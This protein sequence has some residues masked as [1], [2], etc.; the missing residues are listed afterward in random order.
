M[1]S[2][3]PKGKPASQRWFGLLLRLLPEDFRDHFG[4]EMETVIRHQQH[5]AQSAGRGAQARFWWETGASLVTAALREHWEILVQDVGFALRLLRH[6]P[7]FALVAVLIIGLAIG[8]NTAAFTAANAI[9]IQPLPFA[10]GTHLVHLMQRQPGAGVDAL[11]FSVA[12]I[13]D[14]R[15]QSQTLEAVIEYHEMPFTL[16]GGREPERVDTGV[17]SANFFQA[18]GITPLHGRTFIEDDDKPHSQSV[19]VLSHQFWL[20]SFGGDPSVVG[21]SYSMNDKQH[22]VI[23]VLPPMPQ[24]PE[25][26]D[27]YMPT[28]AC[29][30]RSSAEMISNREARMMDVYAT[31]KQGATLKQAESE[32]HTIASRLRSSYPKEY[33]AAQGYDAGLKPVREEL[34]HDV[35]PVLI[36]LSAATTLL[37]LLACANV[38]GLVLGRMLARGKELA[39]R[40]AL[41][42]SRARMLRSFITEGV[43]IAAAGGVVGMFLAYWGLSVV[44]QFVAGFTSLSS[45][46]KI[47]WK[48]GAF[49]ALLWVVCGIVIGL[50]PSIGGRRSPFYTMQLGNTTAPG[51]VNNRARG[52]LVA[53][54]L[55]ASVVLLVGAGLML[56]TLIQ[57][58]SVDGGFE[59]SHVLTARLYVQGPQFRTFFESLLERTRHLHGTQ[60]VALSSTFPLYTR[61][62]GRSSPFEILGEG[63]GTP[64]SQSATMRIITPDYFRTLGIPVISGRAF[65]DTDNQQ[66]PGVVIINQRMANRHWNGQSPI[67]KQIAFAPGRWFTVIGVAGDVRQYGLDKEP[68]EEVYRP[69]AQ[70]PN[71]VLSLLV[72][73]SDSWTN[74][75][76]EIGWIAHNLDSQAVVTDVQPLGQVRA[77]SLASPRVTALFLGLFAA[78]ALGITAAGISGM[79][80]LLV[81][82]RQHEIGIRLALGA[83]SGRVIGSMMRQALMLI[84]AGLGSGLIMAWLLS[85]AMSRLVFGIGPR[86]ALTFAGSAA[87]LAAVAAASSFVPLTRVTKLDPMA[88]LRAE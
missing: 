74:S 31:L 65:N 35:R 34:T 58:E 45:L 85:A 79:M 75:A 70:S 68:V 78:V 53:A 10:G 40:S 36:A 83:T 5:D 69:F 6:K 48:V 19:I 46:L 87:L 20:R 61:G 41:G 50:V 13:Q 88:V 38:A 76:R 27:V 67:G 25:V 81:S 9:L 56:R 30:A 12:E 11:P 60:Y 1:P 64:Q 4:A 14:Y 18:L 17:V 57:L 80:G 39:L 8:V 26:V 24:F 42:A 16:L 15:A 86:D 77:N 54:Q 52:I 2:P 43:V 84:F 51:L 47:D 3:K 32:L 44:V 22:L 82:E 72:R 73:T 37:L 33:P 49:C 59:S 62:L 63:P 71:F 55:G 7:A 66:A 29:P 23:G 28:A 21:K